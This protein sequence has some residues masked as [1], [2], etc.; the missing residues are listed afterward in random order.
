[1][2]P[3]KGELRIRE[4]V[5]Y[6]TEQYQPHL[7]YLY[8]VDFVNHPRFRGINSLGGHTSLVVAERETD[9][10]LEIETLNSIYTVGYTREGYAG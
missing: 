6:K 8:I 9:Q 5:E 3:Y 7:G 4:K 1:M 2:K 10:G